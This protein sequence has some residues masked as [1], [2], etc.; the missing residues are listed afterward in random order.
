[1]E[2]IIKPLNNRFAEQAIRLILNIQQN[3]FNIPITIEDQP[4]LRSIESAYFAAGGHF[5]GAFCAGELV[6]TIGLIK[7][8]THSGAI[9]K[10]FVKSDFRG[11]A[12]GVGQ[13]LL[14]TLMAY[15]H[16]AGIDRLYLG[17][18]STLQAAKR[19]YERNQF[20]I[21]KK[22]GLPSK[23]PVMGADDT[24]YARKLTKV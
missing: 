13:R 14:D 9:R 11:K 15:C 22:D 19:F 10:M 21:I 8:D 18:V 17:T 3:E 12:F 1:M 24:F 5:W 7:F 16:N 4:D 23:F 2:I 6:G 20:A